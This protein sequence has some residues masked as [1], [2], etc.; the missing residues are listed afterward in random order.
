MR[1]LWSGQGFV[2]RSSAF[3]LTTDVQGSPLDAAFDARNG[4]EGGTFVL[5]LVDVLAIIF[6]REVVTVCLSVAAQGLADAAACGD[7][8]ACRVFT[9]NGGLQSRCCW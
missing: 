6:V 2:L 5:P 4:Q 7:S 3:L 1:L 9:G 8:E